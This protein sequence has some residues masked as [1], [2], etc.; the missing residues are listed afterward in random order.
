[1]SASV[2]LQKTSNKQNKHLSSTTYLYS[3]NLTQIFACFLHQIKVRFVR[4]WMILSKYLTDQKYSMAPVVDINQSDVIKKSDK[5]YFNI[6]FYFICA[7]CFL[8]HECK[9]PNWLHRSV[10]NSDKESGFW[11]TVI[12]SLLC[13]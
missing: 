3:S 6:R 7:S 4:D 2:I 1:M 12:Y 11:A 9:S 13:L 8:F 5:K 10:R